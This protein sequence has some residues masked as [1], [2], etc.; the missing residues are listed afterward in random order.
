MLIDHK[1]DHLYSNATCQLS[2]RYGHINVKQCIR[3]LYVWK[4]Q[5]TT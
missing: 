4:N 1:A 2:N 5:S 3:K